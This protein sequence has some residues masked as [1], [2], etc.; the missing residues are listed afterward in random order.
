MI[1][2]SWHGHMYVLYSVHCTVY[3]HL[4]RGIQCTLYTT[5][6][7]LWYT[8]AAFGFL[9]FWPLLILI[10][11]NIVIPTIFYRCRT[12]IFARHIIFCQSRIE[13]IIHTHTFVLRYKIGFVRL[14][15][16]HTKVNIYTPSK[17]RKKISRT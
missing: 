7:T 13:H 16:V 4:T 2:D 15:N 10:R 5:Y 11:C 14:I 6:S 17:H 3:I 9:F 8:S 1:I 12:L